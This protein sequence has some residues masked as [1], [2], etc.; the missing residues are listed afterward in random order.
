MVMVRSEVEVVECIFAVVELVVWRDGSGSG[1]DG[2]VEVMSCVCL[3]R[4]W[5]GVQRD[6]Q[7]EVSRKSG[8]VQ[9]AKCRSAWDVRGSVEQYREPG[10]DQGISLYIATHAPTSETPLAGETLLTS[11]GKQTVILYYER[12]KSPIENASAVICHIRLPI[13]RLSFGG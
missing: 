1:G 6:W 7:C 9:S 4:A 13:D 11:P 2:G 10:G 5:S 3:L 12:G 8:R